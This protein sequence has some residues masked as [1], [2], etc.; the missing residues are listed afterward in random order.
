LEA[1]PGQAAGCRILRLNGPL[2]LQGVFA[3][4]NALRADPPASLILDLSGVPY[5]DSAG[6]GAIINYYVSCQRNGRKLIVAGVNGRVL[7]LFRMT[8]VDGLLTIAPTVADAEA[9]IS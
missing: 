6:M 7:E 2:T 5:M 8:K 9:A 3:F 4:Q 1:V